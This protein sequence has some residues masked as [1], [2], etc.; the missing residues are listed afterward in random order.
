MKRFLLIQCLFVEG[1]SI[2]NKDKIFEME[3]SAFQS[4]CKWFGRNGF[5]G[6]RCELT[7]QR[8]IDAVSGIRL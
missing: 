2:A 4:V 6:D 1:V 3:A 7:Y 5:M 8:D